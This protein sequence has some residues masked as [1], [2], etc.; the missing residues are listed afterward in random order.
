M[1]YYE[2]AVMRITIGTKEIFHEV[3][4]ELQFTNEFT[5]IASKD[6]NG[7]ISTPGS[8]S[9]SLSCN[10]SLIDNDGSV[11]EDLFTL[12]SKAKAQTKHA[13]TFTTG[14]TGDVVFSGEVYIESFTVGAVNEEKST[15]S[16][17]LRGNG[18]LT[19]AQVV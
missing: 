16:Y 7:K 14:A 5:E 17:N 11:Q 10:A 18:D 4:A 12:A 19:I 2:G 6:T 15:A 9:F 3:D 1:A 13:F 8:Q